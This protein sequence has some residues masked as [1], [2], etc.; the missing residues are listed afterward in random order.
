[1]EINISSHLPFYNIVTGTVCRKRFL[2]WNVSSELVVEAKVLFW[3]FDGTHARSQ[4][5]RVGYFYMYD[6][7]CGS[8]IRCLFGPPGFDPVSGIC[9]LRMPDLGSRMPSCFRYWIKNLKSTIILVKL[10]RI[11][12]F[13]YV[14]FQKPP[15]L[16]PCQNNLKKNYGR[17]LKCRLWKFE[18]T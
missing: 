16:F 17:Y 8:A 3:V 14:Q 11:F 7:C 18:G 5:R 9:F 1:M 4:Q 2:S 15:D 13:E 12:S 10:A 6:Q